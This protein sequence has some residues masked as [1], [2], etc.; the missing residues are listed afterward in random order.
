MPG[1]DKPGSITLGVIYVIEY[2][3]NRRAN[4]FF[5]S[6]VDTWGPK[7]LLIWISAILGWITTTIYTIAIIIIQY[8]IFYLESLS[9]SRPI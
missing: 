7:K 4:I 3:V 5:T 1:V 6:Y 2:T 9:I 8:S